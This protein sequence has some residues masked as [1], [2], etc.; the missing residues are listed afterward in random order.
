MP[1]FQ[2]H[3]EEHFSADEFEIEV[4]LASPWNRIIAV[5]INWLILYMGV[6]IGTILFTFLGVMFQSKMAQKISI[7]L[8]VFF[9]L[10][11]YFVGQSI[12][13]STKGQSFGKKLM[14]IKVIGINGNNPGFIGTVLMRS[15]L[16]DFCLIVINL[17]VNIIF[18]PDI[19]SALSKPNLIAL[20][21][22]IICLVML[23]RKDN[24]YRT[25]EDYLAKT[26]VIKI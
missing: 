26:I 20:F 17:I 25:L 2:L 1:N 16:P 3:S 19:I 22:Y 5:I 18:Y 10:L 7:I 8:G 6:F 9:P 12:L 15:V 14:G 21:F 24:F 4:E 13:M 11:I 23:F